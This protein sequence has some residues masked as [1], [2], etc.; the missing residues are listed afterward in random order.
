MA[1][2]LRGAG[3]R[4][5]RAAALLLALAGV[6]GGCGG[7]GGHGRHGGPG[8]QGA[9]RSIGPSHGVSVRARDDVR[10]SRAPLGDVVVGTLEKGR[11][12]TAVCFVRAARTSTG[13]RGSAV[14]VEAGRL[15]GYV[16]VTDFPAHRADRR[17]VLDPDGD[18]LRRRLPPCPGQYR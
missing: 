4:W 6:L 16:P 3:P 18:T 8:G 7:A 5:S 13:R 15:T 1:H 10:V 12:A 9:D 17:P 11:T 2:P 14:R